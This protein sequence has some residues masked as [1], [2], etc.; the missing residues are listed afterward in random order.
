MTVIHIVVSRFFFFFTYCFSG[1][2]EIKLLGRER[3]ALQ[4]GPERRV[5]TIGQRHC[6]RY[7]RH[8]GEQHRRGL[9]E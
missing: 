4:H 5:R 2:N 6:G 8:Q 9:R 7:Q 3:T 1:F